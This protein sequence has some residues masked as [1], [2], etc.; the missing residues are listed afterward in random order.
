MGTIQKLSSRVIDYAE[1][2]SEMADAAQG[3]HHQRAGLRIVGCCCGPLER[4]LALV[5]SD[6]LDRQAKQVMERR[7]HGFRNWATTFAAWSARDE[8]LLQPERKRN[9]LLSHLPGE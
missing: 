2:V 1:R 6:A 7:R 4:R 9:Q 5:K 8:Q 3:K